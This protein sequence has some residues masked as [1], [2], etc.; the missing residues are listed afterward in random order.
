[1]DP[2][3]TDIVA[4]GLNRAV[5]ISGRAVPGAKFRQIIAK[6]AVRR[7]LAFPPAGHEDEK[8]GD[9]LRYFD[10]ILIPMRRA[11][12]DVLV[13]PADRPELLLDPDSGKAIQLREDVFEAFTR[14]QSNPSLLRAWYSREGDTFNWV[15]PTEAM[16]P[17]RFAPVPQTTLAREIE[18]RREFLS[19]QDLASEIRDHILT[20]LDGSS[21]LGSFSSAVRAHG[22]A[23]K[24]H[25]YRLEAILRRV[26][27]WC[28]DTGVIWR[29]EWLQA[30][31]QSALLI[32]AKPTE[33][34]RELV[35]RILERLSKDDLQR[36]S[37]PLDIVLKLLE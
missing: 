19:L 2:I 20:A 30:R 6:E 28:S 25:R 4:E 24:W 12:Q 34:R 11:G 35:A 22:L 5:A 31:Q 27:S 10:S 33:A 7:N 32:E 1:M 29:D 17:N 15:S 16:D 18:C 13:A 23:R 8:F 36:V 21:A 37:V 9:F 26:K 14:V 3:W